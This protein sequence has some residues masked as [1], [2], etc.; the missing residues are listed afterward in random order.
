M[1]ET[2]GVSRVAPSSDAPKA[3]ALPDYF[4]DRV[5]RAIAVQLPAVTAYIKEV[6]RKDPLATPA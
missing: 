5:F 2:N 4:Q 6:R 3:I 1:S